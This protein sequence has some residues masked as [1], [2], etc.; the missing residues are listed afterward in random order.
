MPKLDIENPYSRRSYYFGVIALISFL[1]INLLQG[2]KRLTETKVPTVLFIT[3]SLVCV[4]SGIASMY[5]IIKA[6]NEAS[7]FKKVIAII[8]AMASFVYIVFLVRELFSTS[9][10]YY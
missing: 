5:T 3:I 10:N 2:V 1:V 4:F 9:L 6:K 7:S 8:L